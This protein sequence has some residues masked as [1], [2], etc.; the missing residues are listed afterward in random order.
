MKSKLLTL[1]SESGVMWTDL[2]RRHQYGFL[3]ALVLILVVLPH[4]I[5]GSFFINMMIFFFLFAGLGHAW[6]IIGGYTGQISLGHAIFFGIGGYATAVVYVYFNVTPFIGIWVGGV[7]ATI[8]GLLIGAVCFRL[9]GHYFAMV[10][11]AAGL[12]AHSAFN[13]WD[14]VGA[15]T[16]IEYPFS[17]IGTLYSLTFAN[18]L[19]W[20]YIM[21][22]FAVVVTI[23]MYILH[24]SK[25]GIYLKAINMDEEAAANAGIS[26]FTYKMYAMG[27]SAFITGIGG[28]LYA[29]YS[30]FINPD[31]MMRLLRNID[32]IMVPI[33][34]GVGTVSGAVIGAGIFIPIR[35]YTRTWLSGD[36]TGLGWVLFGFI[37][38]F[39]S[40]Y[41]PG[42]IMNKHEEWWDQ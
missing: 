13:R 35:E 36:F 26:T 21:A 16:G 32:I 9:H 31:T 4:V 40:L 14:W 5:T 7:I 34:G 29:Q 22:L 38:L 27:L 8:V 25:L 10:T 42:G 19:I 18:D 2:E 23:F 20:Y 33:I 24:H 1:I 17:D 28:A 37:L 30:L 15:A 12:I 41:R 3:T 39:I 6:N 11:L